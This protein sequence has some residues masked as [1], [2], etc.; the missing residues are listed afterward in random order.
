MIA[1]HVQQ[2]NEESTQP[3]VAMSVRFDGATADDKSFDMG[4]HE[5]DSLLDC[6]LHRLCRIAAAAEGG[7]RPNLG[8][9]RR[10]PV[11]CRRRAA[12]SAR[13]RPAASARR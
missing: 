3:V 10:G 13:T 2:T 12:P 4:F 9:N 6:V 7:I 5:A 1:S 11:S 8:E